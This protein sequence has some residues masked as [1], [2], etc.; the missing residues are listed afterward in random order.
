MGI[1]ADKDC[2]TDEFTREEMLEQQS[3]LL[4]EEC[5]T[6]QVDLSRC[7]KNIAMLIDMNIALASQR[8]QLRAELKGI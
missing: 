8:D 2:W 5:R 4:I 3:R 7:R 1:D 6:L